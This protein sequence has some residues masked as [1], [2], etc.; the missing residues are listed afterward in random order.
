MSF[1]FSSSPCFLSIQ[2]LRSPH[3]WSW[4]NWKE[5]AIQVA[6]AVAAG[7]VAAEPPAGRIRLFPSPSVNQP[8]PAACRPLT[9]QAVWRQQLR[10]PRYRQIRTVYPSRMQHRLPIQQRMP[11]HRFLQLPP[12]PAAPLQKVPTAI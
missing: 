11:Q 12:R 1:S 7:A 6:V 10:P 5:M 9:V 3:K 4:S 2:Q 8:F